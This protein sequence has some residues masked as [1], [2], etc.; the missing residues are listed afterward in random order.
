MIFVA[1]LIA[2]LMENMTVKEIKNRPTFVKIM[3]ECMVTQFFLKHR[4][5]CGVKG[6]DHMQ[7]AHAFSTLKMISSRSGHNCTDV[8]TCH[9]TL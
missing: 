5:C 7:S 8:M 1:N 2:N 3:N 4:V 9:V 6:S